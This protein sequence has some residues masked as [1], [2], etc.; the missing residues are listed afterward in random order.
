VLNKTAG[1][2]LIG[3][4]GGFVRERILF[5]FAALCRWR[6][7]GSCAATQGSIPVR[8]SKRADLQSWYKARL[9]APALFFCNALAISMAIAH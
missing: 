9:A 1:E 2:T 8:L 3:F 5:H 4:V 7:D 6:N